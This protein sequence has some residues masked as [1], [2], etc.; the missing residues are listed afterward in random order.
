MISLKSSKKRGC[1]LRCA[2]LSTHLLV[3][4]VQLLLA[5]LLCALHKR[6]LCG[7]FSQGV[8][9]LIGLPRSL[10]QLL[11]GLVHLGPGLL[12]SAFS[13]ILSLTSGLLSGSADLLPGLLSRGG[14]V[15]TGLLS[16]SGGR[17]GSGFGVLTES[18]GVD[19]GVGSG[20]GDGDGTG[21]VRDGF[22]DG[23]LVREGGGVTEGG[24]VEVGHCRFSRI[25]SV[26]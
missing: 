13:G 14:D 20:L 25:D 11:P 9:P 21:S 22:A 18:L 10:V 24:L 15:L 12:L 1:S 8:Q 4:H 17:V 16:G 7:L 26:M 19:L 2:A 5:S 23:S 3:E 6:M